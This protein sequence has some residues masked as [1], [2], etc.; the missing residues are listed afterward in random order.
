MYSFSLFVQVQG[1]VQSVFDWFLGLLHLVLNSFIKC[2][3]W[4]M[5]CRGLRAHINSPFTVFGVP[6][7]SSSLKIPIAA[8]EF[9]TFGARLAVEEIIPI[10]S[11]WAGLP[12]NAR[13]GGR[14]ELCSALSCSGRAL[15]D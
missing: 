7:A 6:R 2:V 14:L 11:R 12:D 1:R 3:L 8:V 13:G 15:L 5:G 9:R 10:L 4:C